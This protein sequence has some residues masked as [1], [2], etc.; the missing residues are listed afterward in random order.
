M[1]PVEVMAWVGGRWI[2]PRTFGRVIGGRTSELIGD[3]IAA[4]VCVGWHLLEDGEESPFA[5]GQAGRPQFGAV[6]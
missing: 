3:F 2:R 4:A 6:G 5:L 1:R